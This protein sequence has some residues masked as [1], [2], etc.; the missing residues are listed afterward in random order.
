MTVA[1][2]SN[3]KDTIG[4]TKAP[5]SLWPISV[6]TVGSLAFANGKL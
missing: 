6:L 5:L 1:K 2:A 3:P 4:M